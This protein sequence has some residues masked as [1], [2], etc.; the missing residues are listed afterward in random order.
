M[1]RGAICIIL[2]AVFAACGSGGGG[3]PAYLIYVRDAQGSVVAAV[4]DQGQKVWETHDDSYGLRL[5]SSGTAVPREFL[6]QPLD[7]ETGFYQF[8]YRMY[9]PQSAQWLSPDPR[10]IVDPGACAEQPEKCNPYAYGGDRP[11]EWIDRDGRWADSNYRVGSQSYQAITL[12]FVGAGSAK[13]ASLVSEAIDRSNKLPGNRPILSDVRAYDDPSQAPKSFTRV[14]WAADPSS[15][16]GRSYYDQATSTIIL[17]KDARDSD[18][19]LDIINH[20]IQHAMGTMKEG[21]DEATK[22]SLP[23]Y[24]HS[25]MGNFLHQTETPQITPQVLQEEDGSK[26]ADQINQ[27]LTAPTPDEWQ[28]PGSTPSQ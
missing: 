2:T 9:D 14:A 26:A 19:V 3:Q 15:H 25:I 8:E 6:D 1:A 16:D 20:E 13:G 24:E 21:Y 10:S 27:G 18:H 5:S 4:D 28:F 7:E 23:G 11:G 17:C 22:Q 12:A